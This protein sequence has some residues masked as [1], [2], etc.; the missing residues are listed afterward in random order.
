MGPSGATLRLI[1]DGRSQIA[2]GA[3]EETT[4]KTLPVAI[5]T[6]RGTKSLFQKS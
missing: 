5:S 2:E 4:S 3:A 6:D 1:S